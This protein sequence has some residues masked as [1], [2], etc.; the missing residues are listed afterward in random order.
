MTHQVDKY[1]HYVI[2]KS[3]TREKNMKKIILNSLVALSL[4]SFMEYI[5]VLPESEAW[6]VTYTTYQQS[7]GYTTTYGSDGSRVEQIN[8]MSYYHA[9]DNTIT[10]TAE[11]VGNTTYFNNGDQVIDNTG[12]NN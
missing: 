10:E 6:A 7:P 1:T 8:E 9:P 2:I 3:L 12:T 4:I 11:Q 5:E